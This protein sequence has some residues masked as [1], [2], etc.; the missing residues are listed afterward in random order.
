M[1]DASG[2]EH[3]DKGLFTSSGSGV[4]PASE[5]KK[6]SAEELAKINPWDDEKTRKMKMKLAKMHAGN[7]AIKDDIA[8]RK[9]HIEQMKKENA[10]MKK[11][12][13]INAAPMPPMYVANSVQTIE[14]DAPLSVQLA[15]F[16]EFKGVLNKT[17]GKKTP[18]VQHLDQAAF[19]RI[20]NAWNSA[21]SPELLVDADHLS[22]EGGSTK[23][24]AWASNLR[25][26]TNDGRGS[27]TP[28]SPS[29]PGLYADFRFTDAGRAA[30]NAREYRFV[31]PV[32][33]CDENGEAVGLQSVALTNRPNLPVSCVLNRESS[34][35]NNVEDNEGKPN[36]EKILS[37]LGLG[38][39]ASEDDAVAAID[40]LKKKIADNEAAALNAEAE[41]FADDNKDRIENRQAVVDLYVKNGKD[42]A[43]AFLAAFKA[44]EKAPEKPAQT[45]L[46]A[47]S[48][49]TPGTVTPLR[50]GLAKCKNAAER[51]AYVTAHA[52]EFAAEGK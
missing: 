7:Q 5:L 47:K 14:G 31:S 12:L 40:G 16:G 28:E 27:G 42:V 19:E 3:D 49:V 52:A 11:E 17:D 29:V 39:D 26:V 33:N 18:I 51:C 38:S 6:K 2:H 45:V 43:E 8:K 21:G 32:F 15:P 34:G 50:E 9:A 1:K 22:C 30:V 48:G 36:M 10:K 44:P 41:K 20:L 4:T 37:A 23:A 35:V 46:N 13:G 24:F 25:I